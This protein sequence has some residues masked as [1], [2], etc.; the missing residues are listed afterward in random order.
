MNKLEQRYSEELEALR[1]EGR[2]RSWRFEPMKL[3]LAPS[4]FYNVDFWVVL[5]DDTVELHEVK[6]HWEDDARVKI[7]VAAEMFHEFLFRGV[8]WDQH[9]GWMYEVFSRDSEA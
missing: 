7:K 9:A 8:T 6:G 1:L 4:T 5:E 2:V 3:K